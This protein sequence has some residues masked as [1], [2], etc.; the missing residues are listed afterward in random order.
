[1]NVYYLDASALVKCYVDE[2]GSYWMRSIVYEKWSLLFVSRMAI[3][4]VI[5]AFARRMHDDALTAEEF[6]IVRDAFKGDCVAQYH[7]APPDMS[8]I[9]LA[10]ALL[11]RH[12]LRA[13]DAVHLATALRVQQFIAAR[14]YPSLAFLSADNRLNR[15]AFAEGLTVDNPNE[16]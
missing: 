6:A 14:G 5:S 13:Y 11:K 15:A 2:T 16:H 3:V 9:D 4:E 12:P 10:V 7:I 8:V 1:M